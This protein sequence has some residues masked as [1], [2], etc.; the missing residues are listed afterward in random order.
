MNMED[1]SNEDLSST[2]TYSLDMIKQLLSAYTS[3][4]AEYQQNT[5]SANYAD[6]LG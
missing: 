4:T 2:D 6:L 5:Y 1:L 3:N